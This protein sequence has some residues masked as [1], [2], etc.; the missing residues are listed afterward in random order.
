MS[1][2]SYDFEV[3]DGHDRPTRLDIA[4]PKFGPPAAIP[5]RV[6]TLRALGVASTGGLREF[7]R[8]L[9]A[10]LEAAA[11]RIVV[12]MSEVG[13]LDSS[14]LSLLIS[15]LR[16]CRERG[17]DLRLCAFQSE[18]RLTMDYLRMDRVFTIHET[19]VDARNQ[20]ELAIGD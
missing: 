13:A 16:T 12:D 15:A 4:L 14:M 3:E 5:T 1:N 11:P 8:Q 6:T 7:H 17:G 10:A 2:T 9:A 18:V 19:E 20:L